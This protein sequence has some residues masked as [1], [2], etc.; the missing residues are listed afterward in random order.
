M[1]VV[2]IQVTDLS[3]NSYSPN[4]NRTMKNVTQTG[5]GEPQSKSCT[6]WNSDSAEAQLLL[7]RRTFS[8]SSLQSYFFSMYHPQPVVIKYL[9]TNMKHK[10][11]RDNVLANKDIVRRDLVQH[12]PCKHFDSVRTRNL[13]ALL[14]VGKYTFFPSRWWLHHI[15]YGREL[16][17]VFI[18]VE[19]V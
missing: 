12:L 15:R 19:Y 5:S 17:C 8:I 9:Q 1:L 6:F 10:G 2:W 11:N 13:Q 14:H 7:W 3:T 18:L 16:L 4:C